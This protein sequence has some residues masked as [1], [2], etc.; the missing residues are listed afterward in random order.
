VA[1][2]QR[3][4]E[5]GE[6]AEGLT[7]LEVMRLAGHADFKTTHRCYLKVRD[8]LVDR[9]RQASA[10][11]LRWNLARLARAPVFAH[12]TKK[13]G[14][15]KRLSAYMLQQWAGPDLNR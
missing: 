13:A 14:N 11:V 7:E 3:L 6:V 10:R 4:V 2:P 12:P 1:F 5:L 15:R 8:G 9:A